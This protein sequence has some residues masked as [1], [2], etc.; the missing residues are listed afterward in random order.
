[1]TVMMTDMRHYLN[2]D[3]QIGDLPGPALNLV[4]FLG[5]IVA[6]MTQIQPGKLDRTN[7][8]CERRP[9]KLRC[10]AEIC[11]EFEGEAIMWQCVLCGDAGAIRGWQNSPWDRSVNHS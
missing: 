6:W 11:A 2:E 4:L 10:G 7:L 9:G 8:H 5:S 3:G 1:M